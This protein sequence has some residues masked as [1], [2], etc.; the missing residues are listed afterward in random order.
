MSLSLD[1]DVESWPIAGSFTISRGSRTEAKVIVARLKDGPHTGRGEC[2]PYPRY[3]ETVES[4]AEQ[5]RGVDLDGLDRETLRQRL[6]AG[7]ARNAIDCALWDL[8]A[9]RDGTS[10]ADRCGHMVARP[11]ETAYTISLGS[12]SDMASA[13]HRAGHNH[14]LKLK[15]GGEGDAE[16]VRAVRAA[17]PRVPLIVDANESWSEHNILE[18][19]RAC[20]ESHV[21]LIEQPLPAG[22]DEMLRE[23]PHVAPICADESL[24]TLAD[25]D[26]LTGKYDAVNVK[27]DKAGG[28]TEALELV[29][30]ARRRGYL[31]MIGCM[32]GTSLAMAPAVILAQDA[33]V[34]DLDGPLLL[35]RDR[36][37]GL[38]YVGS[39]VEPPTPQLW[40]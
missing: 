22:E 14:V 9:K 28:L 40:G 4:V 26:G 13:A 36:Q 18:N 3:G 8:E 30:E 5:I 20:A 17:M 10:A 2:V 35:A 21:Q 33:D 12:P 25:L 39:L 31:I 34:V 7:A 11:L 16:R 1:L 38:V 27:L 15:L 6:P 19:M 32:V 23:M 24:H 29:R 37:P